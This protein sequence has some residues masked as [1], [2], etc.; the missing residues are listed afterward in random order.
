MML[1]LN[2]LLDG[3]IYHVYSCMAVINDAVSTINAVNI[4]IGKHH[5]C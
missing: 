4:V 2:V 1:L 3:Q 5:I